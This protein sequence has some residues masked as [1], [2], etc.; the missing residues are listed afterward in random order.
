M[1]LFRF[2]VSD[3]PLVEVDYR[4]ITEM[5]VKD[6]KKLQP[7][8]DPGFFQ[9]WDEV[10]EEMT[11]LFAENESAFDSLC[12]IACNNPP[13]DLEFY[14]KD[15]YVYSL[16]GDCRE[17]SLRQLAAYVMTN[18]QV[19]DNAQLLAFWAGDGKQTLKTSKIPLTEVTDSQLEVI[20]NTS[21]HLIKFV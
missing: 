11:V 9:S 19:G 20:Q 1:S 13:F 7:T 10:D 2:L 15:K 12:I 17:T 14:V 6:I 4:G 21:G 16:G 18:I 3:N 5:K 8:P